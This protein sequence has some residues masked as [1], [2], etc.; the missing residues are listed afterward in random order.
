MCTW[1]VLYIAHL[2][3]VTMLF[4]IMLQLLCIIPVYVVL[5]CGVLLC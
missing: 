3:Y 1:P 2:N 4:L 5:L